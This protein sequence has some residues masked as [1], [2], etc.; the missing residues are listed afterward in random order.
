MFGRLRDARREG[1]GQDVSREVSE[2][3]DESVMLGCKEGR[4]MKECMEGRDMSECK[5]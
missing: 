4:K 2:R 1:I 3:M 5:Q